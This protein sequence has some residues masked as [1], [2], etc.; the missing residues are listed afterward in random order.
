MSSVADTNPFY[1]GDSDDE[2]DWEQVDVPVAYD[3]HIG[4]EPEAEPSTAHAGIEIT[5]QSARGKDND[6]QTR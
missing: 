6:E 4:D 3:L 2:D 1:G 5:I